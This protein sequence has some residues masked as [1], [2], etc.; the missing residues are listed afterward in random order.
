MLTEDVHS[1]FGSLA[2]NYDM[3][4]LASCCPIS[5]IFV[6]LQWCMHCTWRLEVIHAGAHMQCMQAHA[7]ISL[8]QVH[9]NSMQAHIHMHVAH[10]H[11]FAGT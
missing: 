6:V 5:V 7:H 4:S 10:A 8:R 3:C 2:K 1:W 9:T 11:C